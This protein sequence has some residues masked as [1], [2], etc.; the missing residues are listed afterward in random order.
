MVGLS[1]WQAG[2]KTEAESTWS[3]L[4]QL[5]PEGDRRAVMLN[6]WIDAAKGP[7]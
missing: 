2:R 6:A 7:Q 4:Q 3:D 5:V 1:D